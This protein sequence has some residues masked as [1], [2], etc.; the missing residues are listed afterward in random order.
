VACGS[1]DWAAIDDQP[2]LSAALGGCEIVIIEG[3][4]V[5][6]PDQLPEPFAAAVL[7]FLDAN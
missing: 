1:D 7:K 3:G 6:L 5:P 2:R 4:G